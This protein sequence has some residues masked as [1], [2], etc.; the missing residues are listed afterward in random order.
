MV[1]PSVVAMA[2]R[3]RD[4]RVELIAL[5]LAQRADAH[6]DLLRHLAEGQLVPE[7]PGADTL[8]EAGGPRHGRTLSSA[9]E[10]VK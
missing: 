3:V 8:S 4:G 1:V 2:F 6:P 9:T 5:E 10:K 7:P